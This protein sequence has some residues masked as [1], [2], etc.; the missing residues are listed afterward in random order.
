[1]LGDRDAA[2]IAWEPAVEA[3][4]P[5][6]KIDLYDALFASVRNDPRFVAALDRV[7]RQTEEMR[8]RVDFS[9][10]DDGSRAAPRRLQSADAPRPVQLRLGVHQRVPL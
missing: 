3:G 1:M 2:L 4:F 8:A 5:E 7:R 6:E 9:V 10:I